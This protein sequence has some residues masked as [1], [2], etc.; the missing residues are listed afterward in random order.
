MCWGGCHAF[1]RGHQ[2]SPHS[3]CMSWLSHGSANPLIHRPAG[4]CGAPTD[5][6][7]EPATLRWINTLTQLWSFSLRTDAEQEFS[8]ESILLFHSFPVEHSMRPPLLSVLNLNYIPP[9]PAQSPSHLHFLLSIRLKSAFLSYRL[10]LPLILFFNKTFSP[11]GLFYF[12]N[13]SRS[14]QQ[15]RNFLKGIALLYGITS[16]HAH[17]II[18]RLQTG[19]GPWKHFYWAMR[20]CYCLSKKAE[21]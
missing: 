10:F 15:Q 14:L 12:S 20:K 2:F 11:E 3:L 21:Q 13:D 16:V 8:I 6:S 19:T 4:G 18:Y 1:W 17:A 5:R 9:S 7:A